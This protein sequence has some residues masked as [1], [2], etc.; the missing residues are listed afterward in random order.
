MADDSTPV[1]GAPVTDPRIGADEW[2]SRSGERMRSRGGPIG[3]AE[4]QLDR[5][6]PLWRFVGF[7]GLVALV[8]VITSDD[9]LIRIGTVT[10]VFALLALGLNV[11]VGFAGLLDLGY[12]AY[13]GFGA[14]GYAML[15]SSKFGIHWQAWAAIPVVVG[16]AVLLGFFL[17]LPSRRLVGDYMAIVTLFFGQ[18]F[19]TVLVQ[20]Y[21]V[22]LL[23]LNRDLGLKGS[24]DLTGG[25]NGIAN[26][27]GFR[28]GSTSAITD[29]AYFYISLGAVVLVFAFLHFANNSRTGRAWRALNDDALAA[30]VMSMGINWLKML[31]IGVGAG[32]GALAGTINAAL[33]QGA[34]P[35]DYNTMVLITIYAVVI[36]GG[37]GSLAGAVLGAIVVTIGLEAL[38]PGTEFA[39]WTSNG[40][41]LFYVTIL[42]IILTALRPWKR[43][44]FVL[45]GTLVFGILM[46][47]IVGAAWPRGVHGGILNSSNTFD[48]GGSIGWAIRHWLVLPSGT[49]QNGGYTVFNYLIVLL[50]AMILCLTLVKG[51]VR[52]A[53][54]IPTIWLAALVYE[55]RLIEEGSGATRFL[56]LGAG[57]IVIM[58][59]RPQGLLGK[60]RVEIV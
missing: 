22:S 24:W 57:L 48:G 56:L 31:A 46:H 1:V 30:Q 19:Y 37:A 29:H 33:L 36:L 10:L 40:R 49:Y 3:A 26:V 43:V 12:I 18:I 16:A 51:W 14:Y 60:P 4:R 20:G 58:A 11:S 17:A 5:I 34:F 2:V 25:P 7:F 15:A 27:D 50:I 9:Y 47:V 55:A 23:G 54:L 45:G 8:P 42:I 28:V 13:Y 39:D 59:K 41:G 52:D 35:D 44:L 32:V 38:R 21:Q 53:L 6:P